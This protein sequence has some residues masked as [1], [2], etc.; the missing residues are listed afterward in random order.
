MNFK[1]WHEE[2]KHS[3]YNDPIGAMEQSFEAG[4]QQYKSLVKAVDADNLPEGRVLML[5]RSNKLHLGR[6]DERQGDIVFQ[7]GFGIAVLNGEEEYI[8]QKDLIKMISGV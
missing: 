5:G 7:N 8:E 6:I 1:Q 2:N 4:Q 3:I